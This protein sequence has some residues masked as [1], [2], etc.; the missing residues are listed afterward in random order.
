MRDKIGNLKMKVYENE[1]IKVC[2]GAFNLI[3]MSLENN[4]IYNPLYNS[5]QL[6]HADD[7]I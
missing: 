6:C 3:V 2:I 4:P 7:F 5:I 1:G